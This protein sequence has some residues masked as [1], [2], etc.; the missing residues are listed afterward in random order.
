MTNTKNINFNSFN[1]EI[2]NLSLYNKY[3]KLDSL[4]ESLQSDKSNIT[5]NDFIDFI[6]DIKEKLNDEKLI[7]Y[8][9]KRLSN[10]Y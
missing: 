9:N 6:K 10:C 3:K 1:E 2:K 4:F 7:N 5:D 8:L